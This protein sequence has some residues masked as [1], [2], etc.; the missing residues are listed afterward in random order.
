MSAF[1][2]RFSVAPCSRGTV[3]ARHRA[4]VTAS[5]IVSA[6]AKRLMERDGASETELMIEAILA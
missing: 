5:Q 1:S 4:R 6:D 2:M 3:F